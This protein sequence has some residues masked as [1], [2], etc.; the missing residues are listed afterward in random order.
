[1][2]LTMETKLFNCYYLWKF[3]VGFF[4]NCIRKKVWIWV[5][6]GGWTQD[7]D[8]LSPNQIFWYVSS[9]PAMATFAH[10]L[11][12]VLRPKGK[13]TEFL[14]KAQQGHLPE[15]SPWNSLQ[16]AL[17]LN[18]LIS[19]MTATRRPSEQADSVTPSLTNQTREVHPTSPGLSTQPKASGPGQQQ[20]ITQG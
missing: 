1:M 15:D 9:C 7:W 4:H 6:G 10:D 3:E 5:L 13:A 18:C 17:I 14:F 8:S 19:R 11:V 20:W 12:W 16:S 2:G